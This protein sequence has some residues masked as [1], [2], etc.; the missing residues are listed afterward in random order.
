REIAERLDLQAGDIDV[1]NLARA[2]MR[3]PDFRRC[4]DA[5]AGW[6]RECGLGDL[7]DSSDLDLMACR[8]ARYHDDATQ[9]GG[10]VFCNLF[11]SEGKQLDV[12]FPAAG[13]RI[14]LERGTILL[15]DTAQPHGVIRRQGDHFDAAHF[16]PGCDCT[17][18][19][20]TWELPVENAAVARLMGIAFE[21]G[22][23]P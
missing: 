14:A 2:R 19:F 20:L 7:L 15:F 17:Q 23:Q 3:W 6:A 10:S 13:R 12:D 21:V 1:L 11:V 16:A 22:P 9:Y 5:A 18:L 4:T 8:G